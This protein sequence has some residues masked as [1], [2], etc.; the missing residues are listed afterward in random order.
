ML[1]DTGFISAP[2]TE[3][4]SLRH[5]ADA[6]A[7]HFYFYRKPLAMH[8]ICGAVVA[9]VSAAV[10]DTTAVHSPKVSCEKN[11]LMWI[12]SACCARRFKSG[13]GIWNPRNQKKG[14]T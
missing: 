2:A 8:Q 1:L 3:K 11:S 14:D 13:S 9:A 10:G 5:E 4:A 6:L 7:E 12:N